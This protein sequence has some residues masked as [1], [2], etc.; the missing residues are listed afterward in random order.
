MLLKSHMRTLATSTCGDSQATV[1]DVH[2][3]PE[4]RSAVS[5]HARDHPSKPPETTQQVPELDH[6][7]CRSTPPAIARVA[8]EPTSRPGKGNTSI[9]VP[10]SIHR[11]LFLETSFL[12]SNLKRCNEAHEEGGCCGLLCRMRNPTC[13]CRSTKRLQKQQIRAARRN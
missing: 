12:W 8:M 1:P 3:N 13:G 11:T 4:Q 5:E 2:H 9:H 6:H 7:Q 10:K